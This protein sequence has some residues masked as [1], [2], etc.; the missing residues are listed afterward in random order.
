MLRSAISL[1]ATTKETTEDR[2]ARRAREDRAVKATTSAVGAGG[3]AA[4]ATLAAVGVAFPPWS[5]LVAAGAAITLAATLAIVGAV[6]KRESKLLAGDKSAIR[7]FIKKSAR[8]GAAKRKR[9]ATS[10]LK[11]FQRHKAKGTKRGGFLGLGRK[12]KRDRDTWRAHQA[13]LRMKLE[14][15]TSLEIAARQDPKTPLVYGDKR[16][17]PVVADQQVDSLVWWVLGGAGVVL[18]GILAIRPRRAT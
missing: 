2:L 7:V 4:M 5:T 8:W 16:T 13:A 12:V 11:Q 6:R 3:T 15:L 1:G 18:I 14:V 17:T 9:V 10:L